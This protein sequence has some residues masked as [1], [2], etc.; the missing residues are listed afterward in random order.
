MYAS[1]NWEGRDPSRTGERPGKRHVGG[2][3]APSHARER[4]PTTLLE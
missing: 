2:R 4:G 1:V 3:Y